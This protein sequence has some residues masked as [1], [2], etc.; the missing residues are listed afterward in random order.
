MFKQVNL[1][2]TRFV[3]FTKERLVKRHQLLTHIIMDEG[4]LDNEIEE[5]ARLRREVKACLQVFGEMEKLGLD[6]SGMTAAD[7]IETVTGVPIERLQKQTAGGVLAQD[8]LDKSS[9]AVKATTKVTKQSLNSFGRWL[10][11]K[12]K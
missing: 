8:I 3:G 9:L 11:N 12:T 7:I 6:T 5:A 10:A 4:A 1:G 2:N